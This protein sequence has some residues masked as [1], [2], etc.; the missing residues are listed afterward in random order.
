MI[1]IALT[2]RVKH[3][4]KLYEFTENCMFW[5]IPNI[6]RDVDVNVRFVTKCEN[7]YLGLCWGDTHTAEIEVAK[8]F[9]NNT[10]TIDEIAKTLAHELV[11]AKQFIKKQLHPNLKWKN[12]V[13]TGYKRTP[14]EKE[15]YM[16]EDELFDL[17]WS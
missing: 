4:K 6:R 7:D 1:D 14:W 17:F 13:Y 2:G 15:A 5:L 11:H 10:L 8:T 12:Q 16:L 3:K 9:D